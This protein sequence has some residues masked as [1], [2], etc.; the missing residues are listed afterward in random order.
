MKVIFVHHSCFVVEMEDVV[1]IFDYFEGNR[2]TGYTFT[3]V[4]PV[5][6]KD[7]SI[8]FFASHKHQ[9]HFDMNILKLAED[10]E[11]IHFILSK[12]TKM[13]PNFMKK[14]GIPERAKKC[15]EYVIP[16]KK[17]EIGKVKV[18][19]LRSTDAGVAFLVKTCGKTIYHA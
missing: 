6:D 1:L 10:Y 11:D 5:F 9:D 16:D 8:Y 18:K 13:S 12:D 17:Y 14:H 4:L 7:K 2:V 19:T 3:G 15:I